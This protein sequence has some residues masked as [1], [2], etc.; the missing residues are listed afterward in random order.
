MLTSFCRTTS[1]RLSVVA[2]AGLSACPSTTSLSPLPAGGIHVLFVGNSLTYANDL[3][4]TVANLGAWSADTIRV[5]TSAAP[6]LAL[7]DHL[8]GGSNALQELQL[9]GW[10]YVVLQQG[11][12]TLPINRDSLILWTKLFDPYIHAAG[13]RAALLMVWPSS[14]RIAFFEDVRLSYQSAAQS[15]NGM[16]LPA[17]VAWQKAWAIDGALPF[18]SSDGYHPTPL[19]TYAAA[20]VI[21]ERLTGHDA[22]SLPARAIAG[23]FVLS[24]PETTIRLLQSAAH[25]ANTQFPEPR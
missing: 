12:S 4:A 2:M 23:N 24:V 10:Q 18:Y 22:R 21:Y 15:V 17:G 6:D 7:I 13:A 19:G 16:F 25:E 11:P 3:P 8:N 1:R 5:A 20:L 9:G 14:D